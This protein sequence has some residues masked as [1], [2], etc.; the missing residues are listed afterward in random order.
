MSG[1]VVVGR[2]AR[3]MLGTA[4]VACAL[5][6]SMLVPAAAHAKAYSIASVGIGAAVDPNGDLRVT[7]D[8][9]I[10]FDGQFS[11]VQWQLLKKGSD[12]I[13]VQSI[14][15]L[16]NGTEQPFTL[17][18]GEATDAGTYSVVDNGDSLT[19]R[20]AIDEENTTLPL[21]I[22]YFVKGAARAYSD[23]C[24]L[25]WQFIG[26]G[27]PV[28]TGPVHI[29]ITP[30]ATLTNADQVKAW[31]H[32]PLTG[33]VAIA[34]DGSVALDVPEVPAN[35]FVEARVLYP[36]GAL[37]AVQSVGGAH[38]QQVLNEEGKLANEANATRLRARLGI[39][40][41]IG[42][43]AL[44]SLGGVFFAMWAFLRHGR[45]YKAEFP[46]GYL[47]EDPRP[48]LPPAVV[49][50]LWRF[51]KVADADIAATLMDLADKHVIAMRP[52]VVHHDGVF[53]IGAHDE[54]NFE[55]GLNPTPAAGSIGITDH[56]LLE[57][58]FTD[59]GSGQTVTLAD[60]KAYAKSSPQTFSASIKRWKDACESFAE[61][62]G[63]FETANSTWQVGL[64]ALA[65]VVG[66]VGVFASSIGGSA[67]PVCMA[68][69]SALAIGIM[70]VYMLRRSKKG[71]ELYAH[72]KALRDFLRDFSRLKEAPPQSVVIWNRFLVL[73]VVF[74]IA[75]EVIKQLR[76]AV[77]EIVS[78]PAFQTTYWWV[79]SGTYG[80]S[81]VASLQSG[82]ASASQIAS[83][84]MSSASGGG[85]GFSGGGG[86]GGGGGGVSAG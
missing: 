39:W 36:A 81:P 57:M 37:A 21:R 69:P 14:A 44:L 83:S 15:S 42:L 20:V 82:F 61:G 70:A 28:A 33:T 40:F 22:T 68:V 51:G 52:T 66:V 27:T 53:G 6:A 71:N 23:T 75:E 38:L 65:V 86:G 25:Y 56:I 78:D 46:G 58:I 1:S 77:P 12:G 30:P 63:L 43:T 2:H 24:E 34:S 31:A 8:R 54:Q 49:G 11:W 47:R 7:E 29:E 64:F 79:Y 85:G 67:W 17:I 60:I 32:G 26:D 35:T 5:A 3:R 73:A 4:L 9:K 41:A 16:K 45:E 10:T 19:I 18:E 55:L 50:A 80:T 48:D 74:G 59:I 13:A 72:Y 62:Q 84:E 76:V